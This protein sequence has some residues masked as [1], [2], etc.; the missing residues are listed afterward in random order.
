MQT[1]F[2]EAPG[3]VGPSMWSQDCLVVTAD[4]ERT[5]SCVEP[6]QDDQS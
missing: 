3:W 4:P 1:P 6:G 2:M 5:E